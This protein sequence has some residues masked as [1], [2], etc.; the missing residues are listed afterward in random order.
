MGLITTFHTA[1]E[2]DGDR[3]LYHDQSECVYAREI[4]RNGNVVLNDTAGRT[5]CEYCALIAIEGYEHW[6]TERPTTPP[7]RPSSDAFE[8]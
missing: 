1:G 8:R 2:E 6:G 7:L 3:L 5:L 4:I